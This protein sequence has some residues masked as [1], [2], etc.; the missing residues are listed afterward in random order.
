MAREVTYAKLGRSIFIGCYKSSIINIYYLEL[1]SSKDDSSFY[2]GQM[3]L[4][5]IGY[6]LLLLPH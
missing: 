1:T 6:R 2:S 3:Q 4:I 5:V